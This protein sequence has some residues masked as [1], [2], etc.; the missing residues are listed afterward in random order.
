[1]TESTK[2]L[3]NCL[4]YAPKQEYITNI[5]EQLRKAEMELN[6]EDDVA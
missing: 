5:I 6:V 4:F 2:F 1:M 3:D